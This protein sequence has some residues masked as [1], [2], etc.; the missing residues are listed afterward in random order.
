M[1]H[2]H[3][4]NS[5]LGLAYEIM[6]AATKFAQTDDLLWHLGNVVSSFLFTMPLFRSMLTVSGLEITNRQLPYNLCLCSQAFRDAFSA[7]LY[8]DVR[9]CSGLAKYVVLLQSSPYVKH[10]R[11]LS[12]AW[13]EDESENI[14]FY[15]LNWRVRTLVEKM[16]RL[17]KFLLVSLKTIL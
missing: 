12:I 15:N 7:A 5:N 6:S 11:V 9:L 16:P 2:S 13:A 17:T 8:Y 3:C 1:S 10:G 4:Y 14:D